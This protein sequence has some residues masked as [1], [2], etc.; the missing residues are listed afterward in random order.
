M[1]LVATAK[2]R[3]KVE[4]CGSCGRA[5]R[6]QARKTRFTAGSR[7]KCRDPFNLRL[8]NFADRSHFRMKFARAGRRDDGGPAAAPARRFGPRL[9]KNWL[10]RRPSSGNIAPAAKL[11][12]E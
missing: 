4:A 12:Q 7:D 8:N 6:F 2:S 10:E 5:A 11:Y 9:R 1:V 3:G